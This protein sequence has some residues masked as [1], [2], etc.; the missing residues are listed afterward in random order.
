MEEH[1]KICTGQNQRAWRTHL[2]AFRIDA[3]MTELV[4]KAGADD[5]G[6]GGCPWSSFVPAVHACHALLHRALL[7]SR[8]NDP[9]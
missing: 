7:R 6:K 2:L 1:M 4:C 3:E 8:V 5:E 9:T